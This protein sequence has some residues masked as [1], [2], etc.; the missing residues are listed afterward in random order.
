M[1]YIFAPV[2]F[3]LHASDSAGCRKETAQGAEK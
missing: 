3:G 2:T 1:G